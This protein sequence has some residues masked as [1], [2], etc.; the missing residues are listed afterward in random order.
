MEKHILGLVF[1]FA[2][3]CAMP[4][5]PSDFGKTEE[6]RSGVQHDCYADS[7][8][9]DPWNCGAC[10][11]A[12]N[13]A[14]TDMCFEGRCSCGEN[15]YGYGPDYCHAGEDCRNGRCFAV[16]VSGPDCEM[17]DEC[18]NGSA[19]IEGHCTAVCFQE[20]GELACNG[21]DDDCDGCIDATM[22]S[23]GLCIHQPPESY[24]VVFG[25]DVSG[26]MDGVDIRSVK[27]AVHE[28]AERFSG[29]SAFRFGAVLI[30]SYEIE[31]RPVV[32]S[33]LTDF[34]TF[35]ARLSSVESVHQGHE[36]NYDAVY[37]LGT[38][39]LPMSWRAGAT[40]I[41][42]VFTDEEG[43]SYRREFGLSSVGETEMCSALTNGEVLVIVTKPEF[44]TDYNEC[45]GIIELTS[46]L[47]VLK[48]IINNAVSDPCD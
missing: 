4:L 5:A 30:P 27:E 29:D 20:I 38:G 3:S 42:I 18:D 21:I 45:A 44:Y 32:Y 17:E 15:P 36:P 33:D 35:D 37:E 22:N 23:Y 6:T 43:Q 46:N 26:S 8:N 41:I 34:D 12:C 40:R 7:L 9:T 14:D 16:D 25:L 48:N 39:E 31:G 13:S 28:S 10:G 24:D 2:S 19:C 47:E 11:T 1:V